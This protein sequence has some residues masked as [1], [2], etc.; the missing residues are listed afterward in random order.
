MTT[1]ACEND[2]G[3]LAAVVITLPATGD[4]LYLCQDHFTGWCLDYVIKR[5]AEDGVALGD[6]VAALAPDIADDATDW[7]PEDSTEDT[8]MPASAQSEA[9]SANHQPTDSAIGPEDVPQPRGDGV[10]PTQ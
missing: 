3:Q 2:D 10:P 1:L 6:L 8:T 7:Y 4:V 5:A 9:P